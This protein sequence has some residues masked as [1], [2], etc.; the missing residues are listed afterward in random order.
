MGSATPEFLERTF[1]GERRFDTVYVTANPMYRHVGLDG[2][3]H[4]VVDVWEDR[5]DE[6]RRTVW[7]EAVVEAT[8]AAREAYPNKRVL[9]HFMQPHYPFLGETGE[10]I[11]HSG[12]EW[13]KRLVEEGESSRDD[14]TVWTLASAGELDEETVRT[15]YDEN[16]E[17]VLP[18]VEE[19]VGG[20]EGRTVVTSDH[21]NLIGE[22][23]APLD[24]KRYG[25]PLQ[26][27][28]DG[29]RRVPW[30]VVEGS[31]RRRIESEPP[32]ENE[33]IDGS[34]VRNR[35]SDLGYVDL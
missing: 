29:L 5:W 31:A 8:R 15:A 2:V 22:R 14:P 1:A 30:L 25:Y 26:T 6:D 19:L 18:H 16:L 24:G 12:I 23:I 4:A 17:L 28:V 32:R 35:L 27:D 20:T 3:F 33:D 21:G 11:A 10:A 7:P 13:T 34:V 9:T